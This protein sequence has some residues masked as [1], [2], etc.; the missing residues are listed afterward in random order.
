GVMLKVPT[1]TCLLRILR[2]LHQRA[3]LSTTLTYN[4]EYLI[5]F[6]SP[7]TVGRDDRRCIRHGLDYRGWNRGKISI[8]TQKLDRISP[9]TAV[10][11]T[12][13]HQGATIRY[14]GTVVINIDSERT[15][16]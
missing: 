1:I 13:W 11:N 8:R 6:Q 14:R 12:K 4:K 15:K 3:D 16:G 5:L 2:H 10:G 7:G 9:S